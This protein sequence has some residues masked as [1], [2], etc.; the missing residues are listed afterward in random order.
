MSTELFERVLRGLCEMHSLD[1]THVLSGGAVEMGGIPFSLV[2]DKES[3][4]SL[5]TMYCDFGV[6]PKHLEAQAYAKL[7]QA[8]LSAYTGQGETFCLTS[9]GQVVLA[10]SY[11][12]DS[13]TPALLTGFM[14]MAAVLAKEWRN[15]YF[16]DKGEQSET[17]QR[18]RQPLRKPYPGMNA[19]YP[20]R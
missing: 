15:S 3:G 11:L 16:L 7:L 6:V 1:A 14:A 20:L 9:N 18:D 4:S 8:N 12:L 17:R 13:L 5:L 2:H 19:G 10:N